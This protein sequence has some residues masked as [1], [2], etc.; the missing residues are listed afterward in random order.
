M[1]MASNMSKAK[2]NKNRV[3]IKIG[4]SLITDNGR[5]LNLDLINSITKQIS[6]IKETG[7]TISIVSSGAVAFGMSRLNWSIR[8]KSLHDL[9]AAAAIGQIGLARAY[10]D[11]FEK[12]GLQAAQILLTHD[13]LTH[14][15]RYLNA[16]STLRTLIELGAIPIVNENDSVAIDEI[17]F[18][19]NDTLAALVTNLVEADLMIL[20]T[21]QN[22]LYTSNPR[23]NLDAKLVKEASV[24]DPNLDKMAEGAGSQ[25]GRGGM[26]TKIT[27]ARKA[28][29][30]GARTIIANGM[31]ADIL[32]E[33]I[34]GNFVG[35]TLL[36]A[37]PILTSRKQW[38]GSHLQSR[39]ILTLDQG[40]VRALVDERK[41]LL[42][43]G[44]RETKGDYNRGDIVVCVD[45]SGNKVATGLINYNSTE[46][47]KII[48]FPS[49]DIERLIGYVNDPE[50]IHRDNLAIDK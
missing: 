24:D 45:T 9:Q 19:D 50:L 35:T 40:A 17:K 34:S 7:V 15:T 46:T 42:P 30:S 14:R 12:H 22:G 10:Q 1:N 23:E 18:G 48:G 20:L 5:R 6:A 13:D 28:A 26:Q 32:T 33:I 21:D 44:V 47:R 36:P 27:A 37:K 8:P 38:L 41:S 29:K 4:S 3:V 31:A 39:G 43:I 16:R 2:S 11:S 25:F 49:Q